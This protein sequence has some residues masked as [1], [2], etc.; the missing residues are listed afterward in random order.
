VWQFAFSP[1]SIPG[2]PSVRIYISPVGKLVATEPG[3][4]PQR[5]KAFH[6]QAY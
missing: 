5:V 1:T 2:A 6:T 4:L 3:D